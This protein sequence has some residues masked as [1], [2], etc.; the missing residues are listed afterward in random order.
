MEGNISYH[1]YSER[2]CDDSFSYMYLQGLK[3]RSK[4]MTRTWVL[5]INI[6]T[7]GYTN[8]ALVKY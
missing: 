7:S 8:W 3:I 1:F 2:G 6:I 5:E 4:L